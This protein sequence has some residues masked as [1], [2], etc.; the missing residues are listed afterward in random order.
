MKQKLIYILGAGRSGT[1]ILDIVLGNAV[2]AISLGEINRFFKRGGIAPKREEQDKVNI[3]WTA[4]KQCFDSDVSQGY[5]SLKRLFDKNEYHT[6]FPKIYFGGAEYSYQRA[7]SKQYECIAEYTKDKEVLVESSKYPARALNVSSILS[8]KMDIG[9]VYLK[10]DPVKVVS[11]FGKKGLEQ[12]AKSY[13]ASNAYYLM[14]NTLCYLSVWKLRKRGHKIVVLKYEDL[15]AKP[16]DVLEHIGTELGL[17]VLPVQEKISRDEPL[18]TGY[19][20]DGNRIRLKE[21][22]VLQK[23]IKEVDKKGISYYFTRGFNFLIYR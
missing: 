1:T 12:P 7:L 22:I 17:G 6:N 13:L 5:K 10:K 2:D 11:S 4:I 21:N 3:F 9:Y 19:L 15:I 23:K 16:I 8:D 14:V 18:D 20:F